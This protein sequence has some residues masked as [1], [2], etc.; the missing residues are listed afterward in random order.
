MGSCCCLIWFCQG[1]VFGS[2]SMR[3]VFENEYFVVR[4]GRDSILF[5]ERKRSDSGHTMITIAPWTKNDA[6]GSCCMSL[7]CDPKSANFCQDKDNPHVIDV[8]LR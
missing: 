1:R 6:P 8:Y 5:I 2:V 7:A 3:V 4:E